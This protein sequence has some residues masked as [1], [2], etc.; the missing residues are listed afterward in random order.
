MLADNPELVHRGM[1]RITDIMRH[2]IF[3][4]PQASRIYAYSAVAAYE[5]L[6][7]GYPDYRHWPDS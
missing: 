7:P 4:P 5:A 3:S 2:D 1:R 6:V